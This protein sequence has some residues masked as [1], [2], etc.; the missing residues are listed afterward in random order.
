MKRL[1]QAAAAPSL[2]AHMAVYWGKAPKDIMGHHLRKPTRPVRMMANPVESA[3]SITEQTYHAEHEDAK[4]RR[5]G[6]YILKSMVSLAAL[7]AVY[8]G[9]QPQIDSFFRNQLGF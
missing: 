7:G 2:R 9:F 4:A 3:A 8:T 1:D 6:N 5:L